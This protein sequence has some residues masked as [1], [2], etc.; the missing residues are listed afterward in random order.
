VSIVEDIMS[1]WANDGVRVEAM[2]YFL[3]WTRRNGGVERRVIESGVMTLDQVR[4]LRDNLVVDLQP[5]D[6]PLRR[7]EHGEP[8]ASGL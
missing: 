3:E 2:Q 8:L 7:E 6:P 1:F 4:Q 5:G